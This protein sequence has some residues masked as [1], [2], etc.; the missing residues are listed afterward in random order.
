MDRLIIAGDLFDRSRQNYADFER[1]YLDARPSGLAVTVIPGNHDP[2]LQ[3]GALALEGIEVIAEPTLVPADKGLDLLYVPYVPGTSMGEHLPAFEPSLKPGQW[4][5][6]SHGDWTGGIHIVDPNE[7]GVYMPLTRSDLETYKPAAVLLGH[8]HQ[9]YK[10]PPVHYAGSPNPL[11]INETGLRYF[12][13]LD[14]ESR[15]V[16]RQPV[17]S[18]Q[19]YFKETVVMLPVE[20]EQ[21]YLVDEI[22]ARIQ[23][24]DLPE[25]WED[26]VQVRLKVA[27]YAA[28]RSA[29]DQAA[30]EAIASYAFYDQGPDLSELN[31]AND[32][33]RVHIARKAREW[34]DELD[35]PAAEGEPAK[36]EITLEALRIIWGS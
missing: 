21:A 32:A 6:I 18:P 36:D 14:T 15:E 2:D 35:W 28:D 27:G 8:I 24:W 4:A 34:I 22:E 5:L 26:R 20:D 30:R 11:N 17:N 10:Q 12:L 3:P 16:S 23:A 1:A 29:V 9:A 19:L 13:I 31:H 7:P 33:D 25:G